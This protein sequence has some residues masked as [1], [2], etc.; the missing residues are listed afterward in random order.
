MVDVVTPR[1]IVEGCK[2]LASFTPKGAKVSTM[3]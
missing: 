2:L 1:C 3:H